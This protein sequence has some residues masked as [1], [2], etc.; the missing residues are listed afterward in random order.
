MKKATLSPAAFSQRLV[1]L[2]RE[3]TARLPQDVERELLLDLFGSEPERWHERFFGVGD[4]EPAPAR[5]R[6]ERVE[7]HV[8]W[9]WPD[10]IPA[11]RAIAARVRSRL[12]AIPGVEAVSEPDLDTQFG[13]FWG[14]RV[15]LRLTQ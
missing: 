9:V 3:F 11:A 15:I 14:L 2:A 13:A 4:P 12:A 8:G 5:G 1:E 7:I 6:G 10:E